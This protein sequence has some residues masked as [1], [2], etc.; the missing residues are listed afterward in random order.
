M[1]EGRSRPDSIH[2]VN[3]DRSSPRTKTDV[4]A[5]DRSFSDGHCGPNVTVE[6][7]PPRSAAR[8]PTA[9]GRRRQARR[10]GALHQRLG[11]A[12]GDSGRNPGPPSLG[13]G[14]EG[15][16]HSI[17]HATHARVGMTS[18]TD[19]GRPFTPRS[20]D[21]RLPGLP[22][23]PS[24]ASIA[25]ASSRGSQRLG[26]DRRGRLDASC[27]PGGA[28]LPPRR[29]P[30]TDRRRS[31]LSLRGTCRPAGLHRRDRASRSRLESATG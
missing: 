17:G 11:Q 10:G 22:L 30:V 25:G 6:C 1:P 15:R 4:M 24:L 9:R 18:R 3:E 7:D 31:P 21:D 12:G 13:L 23:P 28:A 16:G 19:R 29:W 26:I 20:F 2:F 14:H 8:S 27:G 5:D